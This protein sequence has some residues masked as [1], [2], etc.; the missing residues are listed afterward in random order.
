MI[1]T[2]I[3]DFD[4]VI[5]ESMEIKTE[6]FLHLFHDQPEDVQRRIVR[7]HRENGGMSRYEKFKR[8][9]RDFLRWEL[10]PAELGRLDAE[11]SR[12][13]RERILVAPFVKGAR[14]FL[15]SYHREYPLY[16][17]SGTPEAELRMILEARDLAR[18]FRGIW[19]APTEKA[20]ACRQ[21]VA[22]S[23]LA[24]AEVVFVGDAVTDLEAARRS[25]VHFIARLDGSEGNPL[26]H[27]RLRVRVADLSRLHKVL[28]EC[29]P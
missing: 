29:F 1:R 19:G 8:I 11:F 17:V 16:V 9:Y 4:G 23:G 25:G 18:Y 15:A 24:P 13:C 5:L 28:V 21:I 22:A 10:D 3:F 2:V 26:E 20:E 14:E 27:R 12:F 7:L 6:A